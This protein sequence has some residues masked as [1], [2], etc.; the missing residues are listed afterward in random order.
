[1]LFSALDRWT[2]TNH[3]H[4]AVE[5]D[6]QDYSSPDEVFSTY[7][8]DDLFG[9][10]ESS[11]SSESESTVPNSSAVSYADAAPVNFDSALSRF[12]G[13]R[14]FMIEM[15]KE[16]KV[17]L[18]VRLKE[19]QYALQA[20]DAGRLGRL[21]HNLKGVSLNFSAGA[22]ADIALKLEEMGKRE[23]LRGA[24]DLVALLELEVRRLEEYLVI[25]SV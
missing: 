13:D 15:F 19:I 22:I 12:N 9:E 25:N 5:E 11:V 23:D 6:V 4:D 3:A 14:E 20:S 1:V 16:F 2:Q 7:L 21:A 18:P 24:S 8:D 10:E 17:H